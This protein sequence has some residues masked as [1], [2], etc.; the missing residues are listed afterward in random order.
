ME[1]FELDKNVFT[2]YDEKSGQAV[3]GNSFIGHLF[4]GSIDISS[5]P[6]NSKQL[7]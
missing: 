4:F 5:L 3:L 1:D 2:R 7:D 6:L